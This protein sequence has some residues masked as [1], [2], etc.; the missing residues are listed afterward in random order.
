MRSIDAVSELLRVRERLLELTHGQG[1]DA[2]AARA[3]KIDDP[4]AA[5]QLEME[6]QPPGVAEPQTHGPGSENKGI[7]KSEIGIHLPRAEPDFQWVN[8]EIGAI[9][10]CEPAAPIRPP[11]SILT[12]EVSS[13]G[14]F[15]WRLAASLLVPIGLGVLSWTALK[16]DQRLALDATIGSTPPAE[17][18]TGPLFGSS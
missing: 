14:G 11:A 16:S 3:R 18:A 9:P 10:S 7:K 6:F 4:P 13:G 15:R 12:E 17:A 5:V 8:R 1:I 2:L